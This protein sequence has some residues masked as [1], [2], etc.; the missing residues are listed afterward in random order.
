MNGRD[1]ESLRRKL[2]HRTSMMTAHYVSLTSDDMREP[3]EKYSVLDTIKRANK[4][5]R[6]GM[7]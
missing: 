4:Q 1:P 6:L 3:Q 7:G 2:G 5:R